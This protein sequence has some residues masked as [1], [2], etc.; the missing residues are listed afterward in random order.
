[1]LSITRDLILE[2]QLAEITALSDPLWGTPP[3]SWP[4]WTD[5]FRFELGPD[6]FEPSDSDRQWAVANL[7]AQEIEDWQEYER[8]ALWY[9]QKMALARMEDH[10]WEADMYKRHGI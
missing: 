2:P 10:R 3:E 8:W 1:M 6:P 4:E 7:D 9:E 5:Q